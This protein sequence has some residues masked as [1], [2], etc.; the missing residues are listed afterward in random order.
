MPATESCTLAAVTSKHREEKAECVGDDAPLPAD[1]LLASVDALAGGMNAGGGL[2]A[3]G[4]DHAGR[5]FGVAPL[6]L[7]QELPEHA[8]ELGEHAL[9]GPFGEVP[10][11]G[12]PVREVMW[13]VAPLDPGPVDIQDRVHDVAQ[14]VLGRP[15]EMQGSAP[16]LEAPGREE[17]L[18][19]LPAGIGQITRI[20]PRSLAHVSVVLLA[21][22]PRQGANR[23]EWGRLGIRRERRRLNGPAAAVTGHTLNTTTSRLSHPATAAHPD[24]NQTSSTGQNALLQP[25][26]G[27]ACRR[28]T[29]SQQVSRKFRAA[30]ACSAAFRLATGGSPV[31]AREVSSLTPVLRARHLGADI[32]EHKIIL[33]TVRDRPRSSF[34]G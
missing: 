24:S 32:P 33:R 12:V 14:V 8:V 15:A 4:V 5:R 23:G 19:Q 13:K 9:I 2:D 26:L 21:D 1:D 27:T 16:A 3:L 29:K 6:L 28:T 30:V 17:R 10:V 34:S 18:D 20:R 7:P 11:D 31:P 25:G 22:G